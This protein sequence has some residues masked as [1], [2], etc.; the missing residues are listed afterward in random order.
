MFI[1]HATGFTSPTA[2]PLNPEYGD[3]VLRFP[4]FDLIK[5]K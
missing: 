2:I 1:R 4:R 5:N 3:D